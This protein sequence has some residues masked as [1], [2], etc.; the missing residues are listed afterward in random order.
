MNFKSTDPLFLQV[1][2]Y[3]EN[4]IR[5]GVYKEGDMLPSVREIAL[6]EGI[7]PNTVQHAF[8]VLVERG[9][10][11]A[12]SKKGY[13]V[14]KNLGVVQKEELKAIF[15]KLMADGYSLDVLEETLAELKKEADEND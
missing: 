9:V 1:A 5:V 12:V 6:S 3:Y 10:L 8:S 15:K 14:K 11:I 2:N 13:F 7:N 4:L